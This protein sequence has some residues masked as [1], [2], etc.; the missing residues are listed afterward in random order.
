MSRLVSVLLVLLFLSGCADG[1]RR[2]GTAYDKTVIGAATGAVV[3]GV[4]GAVLAKKDRKGVPLG[5]AVGAAVGAGIGYLF[6]RQE[7][8]FKST[9]AREREAGRVEVERV[10]EDLLKITL[11]NE[12]LFDFDRADIKPAFAPTLDKLAGVLIKYD[13]SFAT[14]VG[15]TDAVGSEAYNEGLSLRRARAVVDALIARGVPASRLSAEG[16]G[17]REPRATNATEAGRQLNRRVEIF[18]TPTA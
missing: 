1:E 10:R 11:Q 6:D 17:E 9:L 14:V 5:A 4:T 16:R 8:E 15:H 3:G 13:R 18:V 12:I 7:E 2:L